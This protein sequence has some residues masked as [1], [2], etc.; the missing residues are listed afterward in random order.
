MEFRGDFEEFRLFQ[1]TFIKEN[2]IGSF[3]LINNRDAILLNQHDVPLLRKAPRQ[4]RM[5][6]LFCPPLAVT[7]PEFELCINQDIFLFESVTVG[8]KVAAW[9]QFVNFWIPSSTTSEEK[10]AGKEE[11]EAPSSTTNV[12][13][14]ITNATIFYQPLEIAERTSA[15]IVIAPPRAVFSVGQFYVSRK[16][17]YFVLSFQVEI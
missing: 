15:T 2:R 16:K 5:D 6:Q 10:K 3:L 12:E 4:L 9:E 7:F 17:Y 11:E 13:L 8:F 1:S 14:K